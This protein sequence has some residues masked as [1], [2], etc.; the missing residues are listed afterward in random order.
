M[1]RLA[2]GALVAVASLVLAQGARAEPP[3]DPGGEPREDPSVDPH[4]DPNDPLHKPGDEEPAHPR[5]WGLHSGDT[6]PR[7]DVLLYGEV[8]WPDLSLGF[9]RGLSRSLDLG[10]RVS[11][12]YGVDYV[13]PRGF[14]PSVRDVAMGMGFSAPIRVTVARTDRVS[15]MVRAE[16]GF[17]LDYL[18]PKPFF[19]PQIPIGFDLGVH[20]SERA[21]VTLGADIPFYFRVAP[22]PTVL[23]PFLVGVT[24]ERRFTEHFGMSANVRPGILYGYNRTGSSTDLALLS[25]L[26][27][28]GRI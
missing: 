26:G 2:I 1:R 14:G 13:L 15:F 23:I 19:G 18:E 17:K 8:G 21:T 25:Q 4:Q 10:F 24:L 16:P 6:V 3:R 5:G 27:L 22:D 20:I 28:F 7:G 12:S 11:L 9:Q